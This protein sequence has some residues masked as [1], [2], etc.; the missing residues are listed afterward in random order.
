VCKFTHVS[1]PKRE[2]NGINFLIY[3]LKTIFKTKKIRIDY[4]NKANAN[5]IKTLEIKLAL[6]LA[7]LL[8]PKE[9]WVQISLWLKW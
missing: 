7:P 9:M 3:G 4:T 6:W 2:K 8:P 1:T 5:H